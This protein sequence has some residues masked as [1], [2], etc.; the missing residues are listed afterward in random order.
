MRAE[1]QRKLN[2]SVAHEREDTKRSPGGGAGFMQLRNSQN[3]GLQNKQMSQ[4]VLSPLTNHNS[5]SGIN[6]EAG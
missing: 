3:K 2:V 1:Y 6:I 5:M 4:G